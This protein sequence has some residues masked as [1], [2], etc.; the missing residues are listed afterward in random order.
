MGRDIVK[1]LQVQEQGFRQRGNPAMANSLDTAAKEIKSLRE[2]KTH[3]EFVLQQLSE[4]IGPF[5]TL[6]DVVTKLQNIEQ[7]ITP[8]IAWWRKEKVETLA[9]YESNEIVLGT[10]GNE[11][12][13]SQQLDELSELLNEHR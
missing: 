13:T 5:E 9:P 12:V 2:Y 11:T 10:N 6:G 3:H 8:I 7:K 4:K 1:T